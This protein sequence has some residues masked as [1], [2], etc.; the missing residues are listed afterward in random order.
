MSTAS[1]S[2]SPGRM[3][4]VLPGST[5]F[6]D[7]ILPPLHDS[8]LYDDSRKSFLYSSAHLINNVALQTRVSAAVT[9]QATRVIWILWGL[10]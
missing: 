7:R 5:A 8:Y 9:S 3:E 10:L 2:L 4:L 1:V 6:D